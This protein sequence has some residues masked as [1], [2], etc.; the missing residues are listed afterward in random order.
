MLEY[1]TTGI[2]S[3]NSGYVGLDKKQAASRKPFVRPV[4]D[5]VY[6]VLRPLMFKRG[7]KI[8]LADPDK[9]AR[10]RL[11]LTDNGRAEMARLAA[12]KTAAPA[13]APEVKR[14]APAKK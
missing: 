13:K 1:E 14:K 4:S 11:A 12:E 10:D 3:V 2:I 6:E 9:Y 8:L 5:G 7:E